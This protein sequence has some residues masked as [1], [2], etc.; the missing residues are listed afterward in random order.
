MADQTEFCVILTTTGSIEEADRLA[1]GLV[2]AKLAACVQIVQISSRYSFKGRLYKD[3]EQLLLIKTRS[4]LYPNIEDYLRAEHSYEI[5][6]IL[7]LPVKSGVESYL[8]WMREQ[9]I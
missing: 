8:S 2:S 4:S 7:Q 9:T 6:E 1:E 3:Q 5:P